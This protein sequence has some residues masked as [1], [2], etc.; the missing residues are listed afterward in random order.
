MGKDI[1]SEL[2]LLRTNGEP[3]YERARGNN[4]DIPWLQDR[5]SV[6]EY[7]RLENA[8]LEYGSRNDEILFRAGFQCAWDLFRCCM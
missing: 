6:E 5:L 7:R 2:Y 8:I 1:L 4:F 3:F